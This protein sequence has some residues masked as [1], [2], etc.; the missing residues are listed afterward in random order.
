MKKEY[1]FNGGERGKFYRPS[2]QLK[3]PVYLN[4]NVISYY[5][6]LAG[7]RK[8]GI[9]EVVNGVLLKMMPA[10]TKSAGPSSRNHIKNSNP[11]VPKANHRT[12]PKTRRATA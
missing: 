10:R 5:G 6:R 8:T 12:S 3:I 2:G 7:R 1:D 9:S 11:G 4:E